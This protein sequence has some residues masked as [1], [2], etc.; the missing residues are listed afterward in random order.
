MKLKKKLKC[1]VNVSQFLAKGE[2]DKLK[3]HVSDK[4]IEEIRINHSKL[5]QTQKNLIA[6]NKNDILSCAPFEFKL[7]RNKEIFVKIS[8]L[9]LYVPNSNYL[10][11]FQSGFIYSMSKRYS[12]FNY[13]FK[14]RAI[15][16]KQ[17]RSS[18]ILMAQY[19]QV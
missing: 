6:I 7:Y 8:I 13:L 12:L 16:Y 9:F 14:R 5:T 2:L 19:R 3:K 18:D 15:K 17:E 1:A 10:T 11:D 4:A